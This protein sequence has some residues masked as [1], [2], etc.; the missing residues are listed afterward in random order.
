M[1]NQETKTKISLYRY[2]YIFCFCF[3]EY[4]LSNIIIEGKSYTFDNP[5]SIFIINKNL[6]CNSKTIIYIIKCTNCNE[7]YI[8]STQALN[9]RVFLHKSDIKLPENKK[10]YVLKHLWEYSKRNFKIISKYQTDD[11][12]LF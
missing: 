9:N 10:V 12:S 8:G 2:I 7:I 1:K 4:G 11:Y 3:N 5:K 6:S